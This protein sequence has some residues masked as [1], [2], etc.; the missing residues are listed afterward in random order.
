MPIH[1]EWISKIYVTRLQTWEALRCR[2]L[3]SDEKCLST[4]KTDHDK[5][6]ALFTACA[7]A[8]LSIDSSDILYELIPEFL[9]ELV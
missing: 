9:I 7:H 8:A 3:F 5:N 1:L 4:A 2:S 6:K